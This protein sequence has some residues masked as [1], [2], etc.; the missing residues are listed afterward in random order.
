M[1]K[2]VCVATCDTMGDTIS[3][4][5]ESEELVL[6][7]IKKTYEFF[8]DEWSEEGESSDDFIK[9]MKIENPWTWTHGEF[10]G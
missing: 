8:Y 7:E 4:V 5:S 1:S 9:R 2:S 10:L 6:D 3:F